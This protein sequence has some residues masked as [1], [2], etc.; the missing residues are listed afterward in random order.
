MDKSVN[1]E[2]LRELDCKLA[3]L[4]LGQTTIEEYLVVLRDNIHDTAVQLLEP[5]TRKKRIGMMQ[6]I[7][8]SR[9]CQQKRIV[10]TESTN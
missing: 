7:K 4:H 8:K 5:T 2:L 1:E 6:M 3:E 9:K 10:F